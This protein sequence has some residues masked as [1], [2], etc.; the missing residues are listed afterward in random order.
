M[1]PQLRS[2]TE[3]SQFAR[4][5]EA[6]DKGRL[7]PFIGAGVSAM[8]WGSRILDEPALLDGCI[9]TLGGNDAWEIIRQKVRCAAMGAIGVSGQIPSDLRSNFG[10]APTVIL[11][12]CLLG[13]I[14]PVER[15][16]LVQGPEPILFSTL[17]QAAA[18]R[19]NGQNLSEVLL[20]LFNGC[21]PNRFHIML[22]LLNID[23][24]VTTNFDKCLEGAISLT[25]GIDGRTI[26]NSE[27]FLKA[28]RRLRSV[29]KIHGTIETLE[30]TVADREN[31][32]LVLTDDEYWSFPRK[33]EVMVD[34]LRTR[35][36][37]QGK[38]H[39]G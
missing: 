38:T 18:K 37:K 36:A 6:H 7:L 14:A 22:S 12:A 10:A 33:R 2:V 29:F 27:G 9:K 31:D 35:I 1:N 5:K 21:H 17:A 28:D 3:S 26:S 34:Y 32:P 11:K 24:F 4:I 23:E 16:R 19:R 39:K 13:L 30:G 20:G 25:H 8:Y 15:I